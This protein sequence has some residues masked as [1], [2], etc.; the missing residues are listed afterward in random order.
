MPETSKDYRSTLNLPKTS[1]AMKANLSQEEPKSAK[2]GQ[3]ERLYE[4]VIA[5]RTN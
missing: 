5:A 2:I 4:R 1:F 3:E